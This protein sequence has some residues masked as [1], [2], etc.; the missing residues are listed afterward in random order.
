MK[1]WTPRRVWVFAILLCSAFYGLASAKTYY[2]NGQT[3]NDNWNGEAREYQGGTIGP[4]ATINGAIAVASATGDVIEVHYANGFIYNE[5]NPENCLPADPIHRS[6]V[7]T[8][9]T[10][11]GTPTVNTWVVT[12]NTTFISNFL[13]AERLWLKGNTASPSSPCLVY[14][15]NYLTMKNGAWVERTLGSI[16]AG[17]LQFAGQAS[18][19]YTG[20]R[21][22]GLPMVTGLE[23][24]PS[25]S[26]NVIRELWVRAPVLPA[27]G[28]KTDLQLNESKQ[29]N[30]SLTLEADCNLDLGGYTLTIS[31][32]ATYGHNNNGDI[33]NGLLNFVITNN[34]VTATLLGDRILPDVTVNAATGTGRTLVIN[35]TKRVGILTANGVANMNVPNAGQTTLSGVI[36]GIVNN[37][38]G[39]IT[40]G[41]GAAVDGRTLDPLGWLRAYNGVIFFDVPGVVDLG[42]VE[43][44]GGTV[45]FRTTDFPVRLFGDGQFIRGKWEMSGNT[46][47]PGTRRLRLG[48]ANYQFGQN[49]NNVDFGTSRVDN[50]ELYVSPLGSVTAQTINGN[51]PGSVWHGTMLIDN[52][53]VSPAVTFHLGVFVVLG[54]T[55]FQTGRVL[56]DQCAVTVGQDTTAG[57]PSSFTN[58]SGFNA[59]NG[60][61]VEMKGA[62]V[63]NVSGTG[64]FGS[65]AVNNVTTPIGVRIT[66]PITCTEF[67]YLT[68]GRVTNSNNISFNNA[69][70]YPTIVRL[71]GTFDAAPNFVTMVNVEYQGNQ[72]T[73]DWELPQGAQEDKLYSLYIRTQNNTMC[74]NGVG[75][76]LLNTNATVRGDLVINPNQILIIDDARVLTLMG[77][78]INLGGHIIT[79]QPTAWLVLANPNGTTIISDYYLPNIRIAANSKNNRIKARGLAVGNGSMLDFCSANPNT[80]IAG[81][82]PGSIEFI[83]NVPPQSSSLEVE[84]TDTNRPHINW[85]STHNFA[86]LTLKSN[87]VEKGDLTHRANA[88]INIGDYVYTVR[89]ANIDLV[90]TAQIV[91]SATGKLVFNGS[92]QTMRLGLTGINYPR[93]DANTE[94]NLT[95]SQ[96]DLVNNGADSLAITKDFIMR[97]GTVNLF[98]DLALLGKNFY[99]YQ[100]ATMAGPN[101][102]FLNAVNP[103]MNWYIFQS[104]LITNLTVQKSVDILGNEYDVTVANTYIHQDG[105]VNLGSNDLIIQGTFTRLAGTYEATTGYLVYNSDASPFAHGN[106]NFQIPNFWI[107]S[108]HGVHIN[109][110]GNGAY[111]ITKNLLLKNDDLN[112]FRHRG[113]M[114]VANGVTVKYH[115]GSFDMPPVYLG[116]IRLIAIHDAEDQLLPENVWPE[117][118]GIVKTFIVRTWPNEQDDTAPKNDKTIR[119]PVSNSVSDTLLLRNGVLEVMNGKSLTFIDGLVIIRVDGE[120]EENSSIVADGSH[121]K[122]IYRDNNPMDPGLDYDH[123]PPVIFSGPELPNRVEELTFTRYRNTK[124]RFV[125]ITKPVEVLGPHTLIIRNDVI[126]GENAKITVYGDVYIQNESNVYPLATDPV[127]QFWSPLCFAG[128]QDQTV[129][130]PKDGVDLRPPLPGGH[131]LPHP[132]P[133][134]PGPARLEINKTKPANIVSVV[135]GSL[136]VDHITFTNGLLDTEGD[137]YVE[138]CAP[139]PGYGQ[140]FDRS[141]VAPGNTGYAIGRIMKRLKNF[142]VEAW[143]SNDRQEFPVG[144]LNAYRPMVFTFRPVNGAVVIPHN[145]GI[146]VQHIDKYPQGTKGF[147]ITDECG[148]TLQTYSDFYWYVQTEGTSYSQQPF[149]LEVK[150]TGLKNYSDASKLRIIRRHGKPA[151]LNNTWTIQGDCRSYDNA[152]YSTGPTLITEQTRGGL[153]NEGAVFAVGKPEGTLPILTHF[154][155]VWSGNPYKAMTFYVTKAEFYPGKALQVGDEI[156]VF[157]GQYCVGVVKLTQAASKT[158]PAI[159]VAS[160]DDPGTSARDGFRDGNPITY[161]LYDSKTGDTYLAT[162]V[163]YFKVDQDVVETNPVV[164]TGQSSTRVEL[165]RTQKEIPGQFIQLRR[166]WNIFSLA[167]QPSGSTNLFN[168]SNPTITGGGILNPIVPQLVKVVGTNEGTIE[169]LLGNWINTIG[170]WNPAEG[171]YINV[172]QDVILQVPGT[173]LPTP[174][175][176]NMH[177][178]WNIISYPCIDTEQNALTVLQPL[179]NAGVLKKAMDQYG[180]ALEKLAF[181]G[182]YNGIGNMKPGEGYYVYV[183]TATSFAI[184][185]PSQMPKLAVV[186]EPAPPKY[187]VRDEG[188]PYMPMNIYISEAKIDGQPLQMGDEV[189]VFDGKKLVGSAVVEH[190][191]NAS[192]PLALIAAM[193]DGSGK[194][195]TKGNAISI[196]VW[197]KD[198]DKEFEI[199]ADKLQFKQSQES[200]VELSAAF[201]PRGTA[202]VSFDVK[203][204][205]AE[206]PKTF[207]LE[208]NYPNPFNPSTTIRYA[209]PNDADVK[210]QIYDVTGK[211]VMTL[212]DAKQTAGF[213]EVS[214]NGTNAEGVRVASG[215]YF[216]KMTAGSFTETRKMM[217]AK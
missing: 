110:T 92:V 131:G 119:L 10:F 74:A 164:F 152:N 3:G 186:N 51:K 198:L 192:Q 31:Q 17:Q 82:E 60:G 6:K 36:G 210:V 45:R 35:T 26:T 37:S 64:P 121:Y 7:I 52:N 86:T 187:F 167:V 106:S 207:A 184:T 143:S 43:V 105:T 157:D 208:Q 56:I 183:T 149:D 97:N 148:V 61:F 33:T 154:Q 194:G 81:L 104:P 151:E 214:W 11:G 188:N 38:T 50:V 138:I 100:T 182:W 113:R 144:S 114:V 79:I 169:K 193:D 163:Q 70:V 171:Y 174:I 201:E 68:N 213:Y 153:R 76:V 162:E 18:F 96:L 20:G 156:A 197:K 65:F 83:Q 30:G 14:G 89:G 116:K 118:S 170:S 132:M 29:M 127:C 103:P 53:T 108:P 22:G 48:G 40:I 69:S 47:A 91:S 137:A 130:V 122:V 34:S 24:P 72:K 178:R 150:A 54:H 88:M 145:L 8:F 12:A 185:C 133:V 175:T 27:T 93:I 99:L 200:S 191:I 9:T 94:V 160:A 124:N 21:P 209:V 85:L 80:L 15:A 161:R 55:T 212:V 107:E 44:N 77:T 176:I 140:G 123:A 39:Q 90:G 13:I 84:F 58:N 204:Q 142:E 49:G 172:N 75:W 180:H 166:G 2:V 190:E 120:I 1:G 95:A 115:S 155:T 32:G 46:I 135:G 139:S 23:M 196:R 129:Y 112:E 67:F 42:N 216:C 211:L 181:V 205:A 159:I 19:Q 71:N 63:Q 141:G 102:L 217:F 199:P 165:Y 101:T 126:V 66:S 134:Q 136:H 73:T 87:L 168:T 109:T 16:A 215:I 78:L 179:I 62:V 125:Q 59:V 41:S 57:I 111:T 203:L 173:I 189:A 128:D 206:M 146:I 202:M 177:D 158:S 25:A 98:A 4:K 117:N 28:T 147:P 195:F 5:V